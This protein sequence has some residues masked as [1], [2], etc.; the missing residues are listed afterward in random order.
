[1]ISNTMT[2]LICVTIHSTA[3]ISRNS[4]N[5]IFNG[6]HGGLLASTLVAPPPFGH[7]MALP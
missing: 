3:Y 6:R 7:D 4:S 2:K 5:H 1:M